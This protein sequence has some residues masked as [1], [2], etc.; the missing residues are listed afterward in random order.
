MET[1][2]PGQAYI[3]KKF[4]TIPQ[5]FSQLAQ[6]INEYNKLGFKALVPILPTRNGEFYIGFANDFY[7][8][9]PW[10][11]GEKP[12]FRNQLHLKLIAQCFGKLH[13]I[14]QNISLSQIISFPQAL[15]NQHGINEYQTNQDFL[16][17][18][19]SV[20][21]KR[22]GLNRIDRTVIDRSDYYLQQGRTALLGLLDLKDLWPLI[23]NQMGLCHNDPAP[24]NIIINNN[25][26]YLIDFEFSNCDLFI[27]EFAL[28]AQRALQATD[29]QNRTLEILITSY[30]QERS[31]LTAELKMLPYLIYFPRRFWRFCYQRYHEQL[32]WT[33]KRYQSRLWE[34]TE[35]EP[36]RRRFLQT[37]WP[38]LSI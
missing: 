3:L 11:A 36:K 27:K 32:A 34:I 16:E 31:L 28:L 5:N 30:N 7:S 10:S 23:N 8:L 6:I 15:I 14:S 25:Q 26:S 38:E 19:L 4:K 33:E 9:S 1:G 20:L 13:A 21:P 29:W 37:R 12:S 35:E 24:G 18:L 2:C 22:N 17:S